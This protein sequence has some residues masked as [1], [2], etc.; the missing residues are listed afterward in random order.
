MDLYVCRFKAIDARII[1]IEAGYAGARS[2]TLPRGRLILRE[3]IKFIEAGSEALQ[4]TLI[5]MADIE[6]AMKLL[7]AQRPLT[8]WGAGAP[9]MQQPLRSNGRAAGGG[10]GG[11]PGALL[12][13][14]AYLRGR[15][16]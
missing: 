2:S 12:R 11:E 14:A 10:G 4:N 13:A 6:I 5:S 7:E 8:V 3:A 1:S 9:A 15:L 16:F